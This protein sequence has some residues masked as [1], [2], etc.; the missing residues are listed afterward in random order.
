[1]AETL[2]KRPLSEGT[3]KKSLN[4]P[5]PNPPTVRPPRPGG[6]GQKNG[7]AVPDH[8]QNI[9][10][11][12]GAVEDVFGMTMAQAR[13]LI[14]QLTPRETECLELLASGK[15]GKA[16]AAELGISPK[17]LD[18]HRANIRTKLQLTKD[19][20]LWRIYVIWHICVLSKEILSPGQ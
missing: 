13:G 4:P 17:T 19:Q 14:G 12:V 9:T 5:N 11:T 1:M 7:Q 6:S 8:V 10:V 20:S 18:I 3:E 2:V 15:K 16:V